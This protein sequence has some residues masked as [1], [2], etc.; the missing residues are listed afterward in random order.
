MGTNRLLERAM[1]MSSLMSAD[2][3]MM[4]AAAAHPEAPQAI[5][6]MHLCVPAEGR[7]DDRHTRSA[8]AARAIEYSRRYG[9]TSCGW[10]ARLREELD[11]RRD[12]SVHGK[13]A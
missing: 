3:L 12:L 13:S 7:P 10:F 11:S 2:H 5:P 1:P 8:L 4:A 9:G 6:T